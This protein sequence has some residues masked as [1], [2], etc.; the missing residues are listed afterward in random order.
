MHHLDIII[1]AVV[2][3]FLVRGLWRGFFQE[4]LGLVGLV[5]AML[6]AT[7]YMSNVAA[8]LDGALTLPSPLSTVLGF[9]TIFFTVVLGFQLL[10]HLLQRLSQVSHLRWFERAGG[11]LVG[12]LKGAT[13]VSLALLFLSLVPLL[14][15]ILPDESDT[16]L[17]R[18]ARSF[19]PAVFDVVTRFMPDSK[20]FYDEVLESAQ[21]LSHPFL[22][23]S[24][25]SMLDASQNLEYP[26]DDKADDEASR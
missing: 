25:Q 11:G 6:L 16:L 1:L 5:V 10:I 7:K 20:S 21:E 8:W 4:I 13:I 18:P 22:K 26:A 19:A 14:N 12:F 3:W 17:V 9:V 23:E 15:R 2:A 24:A